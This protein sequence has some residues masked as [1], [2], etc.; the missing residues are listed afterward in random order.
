MNKKS[1]PF[2]L[3]LAA[4][5]LGAWF[6]L[7]HGAEVASKTAAKNSVEDAAP[8]APSKSAEGEGKAPAS[9]PAPIDP[10]TVG[11]IRG[12]VHFE[13]AAPERKPVFLGGF[14]DC[15]ALQQPPALEESLIVEGGKIRNVM[16]FVRKGLEGREFP[17]PEGRPKMDQ[18]ACI[19]T[20]H[21]LAMQTGQTLDIHNSDSLLHN[22]H[23]DSKRNR[24][25]N[26]PMPRK[27]DKLE[28]KLDKAEI[29]SLRCD[30]HSWMRAWIGVFSH[31]F[32]HVTG[33][34]GSFDLKGLPPGKYTIRAWHELLGTQDVEVELQPKEEKA[35]EFKMK[36][37]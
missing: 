27:G 5:G 30:V 36:K 15:K 10:A 2:F 8:E 6:F 29:F 25:F 16:V 9:P 17:S 11:T 31:P 21:V 28:K 19:Y 20:P 18:I 13:G 3:A 12:V 34:D 32:F 37:N 22:V 23:S 35:I 26:D 4:L 24:D 7:R 14:A 33:A 1:V